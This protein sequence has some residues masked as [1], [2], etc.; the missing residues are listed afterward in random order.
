MAVFYEGQF[1]PAPGAAHSFALNSA[2]GDKIILSKADG[3]GKLTGHRAIVEFGAAQNAIPLGRVK[4]SIGDQFTA[5]TKPSFGVDS[6]SSVSAFRKGAGAA[7]A[8]AKVGPVVIHEIMYH[9][10]P[11]PHGAGTPDD[12]FIELRNV[13]TEPIGLAGT[14]IRG[15]DEFAVFMLEEVPGIPMQSIVAVEECL[16]SEL[17]RST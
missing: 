16:R 15:D 13:G 8:E 10:A 9:P 5:L 14:R 17:N 6:P 11:M 4:T 7:N 1:N 3:S 2:H 12:E